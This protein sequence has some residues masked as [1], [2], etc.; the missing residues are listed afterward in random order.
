MEKVLQQFTLDIPSTVHFSVQKGEESLQLIMFK[1]LLDTKY[2]I[3]IYNIYHR[4]K[5]HYYFPQGTV[6]KV[7]WVLGGSCNS[8]HMCS[9][10]H[11]ELSTT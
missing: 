6:L 1:Y 5:E 9:G 7:E 2:K 11:L 3:S 4:N 10:P 8:L